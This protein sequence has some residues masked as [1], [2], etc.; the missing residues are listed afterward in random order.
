MRYGMMIAVYIGFSM[1]HGGHQG[2]APVA[3]LSRTAQPAPP[4]RAREPARLSLGLCA[5]R[6]DGHLHIRVVTRTA[7]NPGPPLRINMLGRREPHLPLPHVDAPPIRMNPMVT[8]DA[9]HHAIV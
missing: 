5:A 2:E 4:K 1:A 6:A 3:V 9:Q 7:A 8:T